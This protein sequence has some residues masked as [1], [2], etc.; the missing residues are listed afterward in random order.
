MLLDRWL[1]LCKRLGVK[2]GPGYHAQLYRRLAYY[3]NQPGRYYH[4]LDHINNCLTKFDEVKHLLKEPDVVELAIWFHDAIYEVWADDNEGMSAGLANFFIIHL[5]GLPRKLA[6]K[7]AYLIE[8]TRYFKDGMWKPGTNDSK[9]LVDIDLFS[10]LGGE[11][12]TFHKNWELNNKEFDWKDP[13]ELRRGQL[14]MFTNFHKRAPLYKTDYFRER[15]EEQT[16]S[17]LERAIK[18]LESQILPPKVLSLTTNSVEEKDKCVMCGKETPYSKS[19]HIDLRDY[20]VEGCGQ[21]CED[22]WFKTDSR[23]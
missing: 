1:E 2:R 22:C 9:Y 4:N 18:E 16:K 20:Y 6:N 7:V 13:N 12:H 10:G 21:L 17:N 11:W 19:T 3:Y 23:A 8:R 14:A 5:M 15:Y